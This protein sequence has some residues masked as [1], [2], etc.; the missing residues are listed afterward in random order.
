MIE[1]G[2]ICYRQP[3]LSEMTPPFFFWYK[4]NSMDYEKSNGNDTLVF[5]VPGYAMREFCIRH[6]ETLLS[7]LQKFYDSSNKYMRLWLNA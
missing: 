5:F 4:E 2:S 1:S 3:W 7:I 6:P